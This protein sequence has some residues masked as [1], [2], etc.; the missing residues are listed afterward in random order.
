MRSHRETDSVDCREGGSS[1]NGDNDRKESE[2]S[3]N[4]PLYPGIGNHTDD[5]D[6]PGYTS[7]LCRFISDS[8]SDSEDESAIDR[9]PGQ[10]EYRVIDSSQVSLDNYGRCGNGS[11]R[12]QRYLGMVSILYRMI[13]FLKPQINLVL[14]VH[15]L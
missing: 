11:M 3:D 9:L 15:I 5:V 12:G 7:K 6:L 13:L 10:L 14:V 1:R 4:H 8:E 2:A